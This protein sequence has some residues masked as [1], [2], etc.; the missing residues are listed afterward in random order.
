MNINMTSR[1][2]GFSMIEIMIS[3]FIL[4]V[5]LL[6]LAS[7]QTKA[8]VAELEAGRRIVV[9]ESA[10]LRLALVGTGADVD[11]RLSRRLGE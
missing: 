4:S 11:V 10:D 6:G 9:V 3:L 1:Q 5:G 7:L 8:Q 2:R